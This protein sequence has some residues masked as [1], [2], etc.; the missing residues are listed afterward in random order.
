MLPRLFIYSLFLIT[1][2]LS[3]YS[4]A[5]TDNGQYLDRRVDFDTRQTEL[6]RRAADV[7]DRDSRAQHD[8]Y[9]RFFVYHCLDQVRKR[10]RTERAILRADQLALDEARRAARAQ[11]REQKKAQQRA[12]E[13]AQ[14]LERAEE[15]RRNRLRFEEKQRAHQRAQVQRGQ[16]AQQ[17]AE[18]V[19]RYQ[20]K[21]RAAEE[22]QSKRQNQEIKD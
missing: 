22:Y 16:S 8:C 21:R 13:E 12:R 1:F 3:K 19:A 6:D 2:F 14:A 7:H 4:L 15:A 11:Q 18:N 9:A 5:Y 17:R 20:T 10:T